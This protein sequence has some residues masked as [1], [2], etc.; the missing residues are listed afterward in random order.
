MGHIPHTTDVLAAEALPDGAAYYRA[1]I[2]EFTTL[3]MDPET[4]HQLG[5][6]EVAK[7][8]AQ[9]LDV[10]KE[11]GFSGDFPAFLAYLRTDPKFYVKDP[12]DLLNRAAWIAKRFDGKA[13]QFF[14]WLPRSRFG[15]EPVSPDI[16]PFYTSARGGRRPTC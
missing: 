6:S 13:S 14:G 12:Q 10:M 8:H 9:M 16:A 2:K 7:I 11:T 5:L 3:D 15:I 1:Q 4:I